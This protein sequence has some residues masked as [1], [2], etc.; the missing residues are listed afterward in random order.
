MRK[1]GQECKGGDLT[2]NRYVNR[3]VNRNENE[4]F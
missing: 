4:V 3:N 2:Y 1:S